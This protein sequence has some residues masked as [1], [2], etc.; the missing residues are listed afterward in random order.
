MLW[1]IVIVVPLWEIFAFPDVTAPPAGDANVSVALPSIAL[2]T[3]SMRPLE[4]ILKT[5]L[6]WSSW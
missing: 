1:V 3:K 2:T 5:L 6:Y 4:A